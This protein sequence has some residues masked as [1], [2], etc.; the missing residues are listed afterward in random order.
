MAGRGGRIVLRPFFV[1][2]RSG[3]APNHRPATGTRE[4]VHKLEQQ[5]CGRKSAAREAG[6]R[7]RAGAGAG[8]WRWRSAVTACDG[9]ADD[10]AGTGAGEAAGWSR[11]RDDD[12]DDD[13][14]GGRKLSAE[15]GDRTRWDM[16]LNRTKWPLPR[17]RSLGL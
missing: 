2:V 13:D 16:E 5:P 15:A 17:P 14:G 9:T 3:W 10:A 11:V 4:A 1:G 8:S 6:A 7:A 12:D